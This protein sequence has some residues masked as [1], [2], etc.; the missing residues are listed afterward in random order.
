[1]HNYVFDIKLGFIFELFI[2]LSTKSG[3]LGFPASLP[4]FCYNQMTIAK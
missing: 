3:A 1:M 2:R 4:E